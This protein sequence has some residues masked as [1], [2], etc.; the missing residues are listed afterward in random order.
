[1]QDGDICVRR[2]AVVAARELLAAP[3]KLVQCIAAG[4]TRALAQLL[5]V[6]LT[7]RGAAA[8]AGP[9]CL[10]AATRPR[11]LG[12]PRQLSADAP[13][14]HTQAHETPQRPAA[15]PRPPRSQPSHSHSHS[16]SPSPSPLHPPAGGGP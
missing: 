4:I 6:R 1:M 10:R 13:S 9:A 14:I 3:E 2:K 5:Q 15:R 8:G 11:S 12:P 7:S 16:P